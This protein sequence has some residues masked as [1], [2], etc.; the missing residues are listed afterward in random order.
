M[1]NA[2]MDR[3]SVDDHR[4]DHSHSNSH[5]PLSAY[6]PSRAFQIAVAQASGCGPARARRLGR[7]AIS[8]LARV[9]SRVHVAVRWR[10]AFSYESP[11]WGNTA[12]PMLIASTASAR[13]RLELQA[14]DRGLQLQPLPLISPL[15]RTAPR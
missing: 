7:T 2:L 11:S 12:A 10:A 6:S 8:A 1:G 14:V 9:L 3:H 13:S 5:Q 4:I 15:I